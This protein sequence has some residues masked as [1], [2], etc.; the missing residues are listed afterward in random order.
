MSTGQMATTLQGSFQNFRSP[1]HYQRHDDDAW[2]EDITHQPT[3]CV[4]HETVEW[5]G[6]LSTTSADPGKPASQTLAHRRCFV[7]IMPL[8][9]LGEDPLAGAIRLLEALMAQFLAAE[10]HTGGARNRPAARCLDRPKLG[11][12]YR[13]PPGLRVG[14]TGERCVMMKG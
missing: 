10:E 13:R 7:C 3:N 9:S 6:W 4:T 11:A 2:C 12:G 5:H 14:S 8:M 1:A